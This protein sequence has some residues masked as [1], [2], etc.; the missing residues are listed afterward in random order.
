MKLYCCGCKKE[1][2]PRLTDG[3]EIYPHRKDLHYLPFWKCDTCQN[4]VG[5]HYKT[6]DRTNPLGC[7]PTSEIKK[8]RIHIH[9]ILDPLWKTG[10]IK[11]GNLYKILSDKLGYEYH[12]ANITDIEEARK[13][14][15]AIID[16]AN[17]LLVTR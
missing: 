4:F 7:I 6:K 12:T 11:R 1:V 13:I 15:R 2:L 9:A 17:G 16:V 8:A 10:K 3:K 14:Y 5:C